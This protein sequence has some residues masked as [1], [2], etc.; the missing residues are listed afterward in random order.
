M[1]AFKDIW[2]PV[3]DLKTWYY[4]HDYATP[5]TFIAY[6]SLVL[7]VE[8]INRSQ[9]LEMESKR[10]S[11]LLNRQARRAEERRRAREQKRRR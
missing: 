3:D 8:A 2:K 4:E 10:S 9:R 1:S 7:V 11:P 6:Y 5:L